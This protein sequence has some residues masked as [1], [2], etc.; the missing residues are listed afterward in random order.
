[1]L[2]LA[3]ILVFKR[4][5]ETNNFSCVYQRCLFNNVELQ[6]RLI[7]ARLPANLAAVTDRTVCATP[8]STHSAWRIFG[9]DNNAPRVAISEGARIPQPAR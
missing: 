5:T 4:S 8:R 1:M 3:F 2:C 9:C 6:L 7:R